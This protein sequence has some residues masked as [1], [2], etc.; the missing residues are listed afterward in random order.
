MPTRKLLLRW[1]I[2]VVGCV[3]V[4]VLMIETKLRMSEAAS[5][6]AVCLQVERTSDEQAKLATG[7]ER[8]QWRSQAAYHRQLRAQHERDA[9]WPWW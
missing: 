8:L 9:R 7:A 6:V 3:L 1:S 4:A 2:L 5:K